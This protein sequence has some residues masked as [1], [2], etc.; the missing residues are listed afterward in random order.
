MVARYQDWVL[1]SVHKKLRMDLDNFE[2]EFLGKD[3][4]LLEHTRTLDN[5]ACLEN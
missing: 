1:N 3:G 5:M 2:E 4:A